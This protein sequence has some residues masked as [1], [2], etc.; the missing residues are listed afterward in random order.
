[1]TPMKLVQEFL[2]QRRFA[3]VGLSRQEK[4]FSRALFREFQRRGYQP[5]PVNPEANE[6]AGQPC[7][8]HVQD[9]QPPVEGA[10]LVTAASRAEAA[11]RDC[12]AAGVKRIWMFRA[13]GKGSV[14]EDAVEFCGT[15]GIDVIPGECPLMFLPGGA[16][17]HR[18]HG[19]V[20]KITG[21]YPR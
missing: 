19:L 4:H 1:M 12:A 6:I 13:T 21:A 14:S 15:K 20:K 8:A 18:F 5:V 7:F 9:I 11:V 16:W 2:G 10:L 17:F 3:I